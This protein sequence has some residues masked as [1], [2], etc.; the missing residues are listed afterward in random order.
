M[1][2]IRGCVQFVGVLFADVSYSRMCPIRGRVLFAG[3]LFAGVYYLRSVFREW[4]VSYSWG[5]SRW[6]DICGCNIRLLT[7]G[8]C[9]MRWMWFVSYSCHVFISWDM[10]SKSDVPHLLSVSYPRDV[11]YTCDVSCSCGVSLTCNISYLLSADPGC[12]SNCGASLSPGMCPICRRRP[13]SGM[14]R[15]HGNKCSSALFVECIL[16]L[17][18]FLDVGCF[19][20]TRCILSA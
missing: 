2:P 11:S 4:D 8:M 17:R 5:M 18:C 12:S 10:S 15:T 14:C 16:S 3:V 19:L 6:S 13:I 7:L 1:C 20:F 9:P